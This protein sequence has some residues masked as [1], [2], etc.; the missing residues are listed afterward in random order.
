MEITINFSKTVETGCDVFP[1][2]KEVHMVGS[3]ARAR[4]NGA[5]RAGA[6]ES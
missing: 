2:R 4:E 6:F 5:R 1:P 3:D